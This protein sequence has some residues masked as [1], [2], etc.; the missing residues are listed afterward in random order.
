M[1][2]IDKAV[3]ARLK[4][5]GLL[6]EILVDCD[7]ALDYKRGKSLGYGDMVATNAIFKDVR[8]GEHAKEHDLQRLFN[9]TDVEKISLQ[10]IKEGE[11]QLTSEHRAR[12]KEEKK[13]RII[14]ILRTNAVDPRTGLP[15]PPARIEAAMEQGGV[16]IDEYK[17]AEDQIEAI[18]KKIYHIL[19]LKMAR[20]LLAV[21]V[22]PQYGNSTL[23]VL[24]KHKLLK[25][26]WLSDGSL[27]ADVE[28]PAGLQDDVFSAVNG[29]THGSADIKILKV[30]E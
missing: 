7:K 19:P 20:K 24:K 5:Q 3:I 11:M 23:A 15:H 4:K 25:S 21:K 13:K 12:E 2:A 18:V 10:I 27:L 30:I 14:D 29:V 16:H 28:I 17:V 6:F 8:K 22:A 9:T 26:Q 1:V